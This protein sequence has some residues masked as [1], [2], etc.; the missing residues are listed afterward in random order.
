MVVWVVV[1]VVWVVVAVWSGGDGS[2]SGG[3]VV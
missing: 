1:M 2:V 3:V